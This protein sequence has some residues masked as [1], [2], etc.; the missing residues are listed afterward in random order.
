MSKTK[1]WLMDQEEEFYTIADKEIKGCEDISEF[2]T[3]ME[4]HFD[5]V[6]WNMDYPSEVEDLLGEMWNEFWSKY[7]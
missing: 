1:N 7:Q 3:A 5:K 2:K 6:S 4:P